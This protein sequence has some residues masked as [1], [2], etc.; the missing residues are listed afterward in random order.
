[1]K[2]FGFPTFNLTKVILTAEEAGEAYDFVRLDPMKGDMKT[3]ENLERHP[4]GKM[5]SLEDGG[6]F[7]CES[8]AMCRY[9]AAKSNSP[10]YAG[11]LMAKAKIDQWVD[12]MSCHIGRWL[13]VYYW[14]EVIKPKFFQQE[15]DK[16]ALEEAQMFLDQ[17]LP[18][19]EKQLAA[20]KYLA[21]ASVTI[22]DTFGFSYFTI[23]DEVS[24]S[25]DKYPNLV[26]W[27]ALMSD[28]PAYARTKDILGN[29]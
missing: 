29:L 27:I 14:Q 5:P 19:L 16:A 7:L 23:L 18:V 3:P 1:M 21:G 6:Q 13:Q 4:F 26:R 22:A 28:S 12:I 17:Q 8:A 11:D 20:N 24:L 25:V 10:L 15:T 9:I 2:I